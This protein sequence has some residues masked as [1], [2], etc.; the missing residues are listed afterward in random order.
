[1]RFGL[2]EESEGNAKI[3][4]MVEG[5]REEKKWEEVRGYEGKENV[6]YGYFLRR[7]SS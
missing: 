5:V 6:K 1:M 7:K 4:S 2:K 3:L